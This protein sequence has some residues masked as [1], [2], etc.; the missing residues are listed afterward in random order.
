M[1]FPIFHADFLGNRMIIAIIGILHVIINHGLAVGLMPLITAIEHYGHKT[2]N[3]KYDNL[4]HK[5]LFIAFIITTT[6]GALTG[7]GIWLSVG[8]INPYSIGSLIRVFFWA[9]FIE[10]L[11]FVT[12]VC[13]I[14]W[15]YLSWDKYKNNKLKHIKIGYALSI[16]SWITMAIIVAI[17]GFMMDPGN[18]LT[19][20]SFFSAVFNNI[21]IPQLMFRTCLAM[22]EAGI[23]AAFIAIIIT[24]SDVIFRSVILRFIGLWI[25]FWAPL[26]VVFGYWYYSRVPAAMAENIPIA[27][28]TG[29]FAS[30]NNQLLV[31]IA[32]CVLSFLVFAQMA[33]VTP[34][35]I[36]SFVPI[37]PFLCVMWLTGHFE[38]I[39]EFIRKPYVIGQYMYANGVRVQDYPL[40]NAEGLMAHATYRHKLTDD[41]A[42][43]VEEKLFSKIEDG[44][45]VFLIACSRCHTGAGVNSITA[46]FGKLLGTEE[47]QAAEIS[48]YAQD[49]H[50]IQSY[51]PPFPGNKEDAD[52]LAL[53]IKQLRKTNAKVLAADSNGVAINIHQK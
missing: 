6:V 45:N 49:V 25:T 8:L 24:K 19:D 29:A 27:L 32:A 15:Y 9:W 12:E 53:Y 21:Y 2:N 26:M 1:D 4:A 17:L 3:Q 33:I 35:K 23:I 48:Q 20:K 40:L 47:W 5:L 14:L 51:M 44:K 18:W 36:P 46:K 7:V 34:K 52:N 13:L 43:D 41:E 22:M 16:F 30:W 28:L 37:V 42:K 10:W 11:V 39:R 38:R 31:I 50:S